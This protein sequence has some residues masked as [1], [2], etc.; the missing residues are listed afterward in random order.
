MNL[1]PFYFT[2]GFRF[3]DEEHPA[4]QVLGIR[5][6]PD[7]YVTVMAETEGMARDIANRTIKPWCMQNYHQPPKELYPLGNL[8]TI[9]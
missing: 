5:I 4:A 8:K 9:Q 6:H 7:G 2:F 1:Q 3:S